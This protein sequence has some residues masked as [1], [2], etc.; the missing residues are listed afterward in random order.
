[1]Q[2]VGN[3]GLTEVL[4]R[5]AELRNMEQEKKIP[6]PSSREILLN[7]LSVGFDNYHRRHPLASFDNLLQS[8]EGATVQ[9]QLRD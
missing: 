4:C 6:T 8:Y 2:F 1:M 9:D 5:I 3:L 7:Q